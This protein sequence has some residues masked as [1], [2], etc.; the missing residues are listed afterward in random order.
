MGVKIWDPGAAV[1]RA[2]RI[3]AEKSGVTGAF[4]VICNDYEFRLI[5]QETGMSEADILAHAAPCISQ[6]EK[7]LL[8]PH[9]DGVEDVV[10]RCRPIGSRIPPVSGMRSAAGS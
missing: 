5:R 6:G 8:D 1:R 10:A 3:A 4:M 7:G 2:W 9:K